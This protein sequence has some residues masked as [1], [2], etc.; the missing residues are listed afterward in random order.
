MKLLQERAHFL[1]GNVLT[2]LGK[3]AEAEQHFGTFQELER[4]AETPGAGKPRIY[5]QSTK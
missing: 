1:M 4:V 3:S 2:K 5:T